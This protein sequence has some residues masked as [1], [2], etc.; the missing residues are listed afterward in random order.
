M[1]ESTGEDGGKRWDLGKKAEDGKGRWEQERK[2][3][4]KKKKEKELAV[5]LSHLASPAGATAGA[6]LEPG[7]YSNASSG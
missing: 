5:P 3:G 1:R 7:L 2:Q 4:E 6:C